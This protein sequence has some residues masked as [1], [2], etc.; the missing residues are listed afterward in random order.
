[1]ETTR[2]RGHYTTKRITNDTYTVEL[3]MLE[4]GRWLGYDAI[5]FTSY[6]DKVGLPNGKQESPAE[7]RM[8]AKLVWRVN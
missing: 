7:A 2:V 8:Y 6:G 3:Q 1:M 5:D 4:N